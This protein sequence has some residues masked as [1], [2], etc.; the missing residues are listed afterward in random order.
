MTQ[1]TVLVVGAGV[2]GHRHMAAATL[3]GD[4]ILAVVDG[5]RARADA[6]AVQYSADAFAS[7]TDALAAVVPDIVV[8]ATP[9]S[10]HH[11]QAV[12]ALTAGVDVLVEKPHRVPGEDAAELARAIASGGGRYAVGMTTRHWPG[13]RAVAS[14]IS[15]RELGAVL[16]YSDRMHFT[17]TPDALAP[18]YFDRAISGGG[19][20]LTNGCHA[21]DRAR[22]LLGSDL[23][24]TS[25]RLVTVIPD[26]GV[27]DSAELRLTAADGIPVDLSMLWSSGEPYGTGLTITGTDGFA[28]VNMDGRWLVSGRNGER[29]GPAITEQ[30]PFDLQWASFIAAEQGF[31]LADLEP[32]LAL[33]EQCYLEVTA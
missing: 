4:R 27:E 32:S 33:I 20:L 9:S 2:I 21:L 19:V 14:A 17:L 13:M 25:A 10:Q 15:S 26:H 11:A 5:D 31:G 28:H 30:E 6:A 29:S 3:N 12:E 8:I 16:S 7:L 18:W 1:H 24:L 22:A 23:A